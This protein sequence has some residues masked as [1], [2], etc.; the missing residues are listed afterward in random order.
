M[1]LW[2]HTGVSTFANRSK[3]EPQTQVCKRAS[4]SPTQEKLFFKISFPSKKN[5]NRK[6][7]TDT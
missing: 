6:R 2:H 5:L 4:I 3:P 7:T 1:I